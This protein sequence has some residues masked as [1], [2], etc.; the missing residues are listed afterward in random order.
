MMNRINFD[1]HALIR[2]LRVDEKMNV[3]G[4]MFKDVKKQGNCQK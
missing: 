2:R 3:M 4:G 1:D